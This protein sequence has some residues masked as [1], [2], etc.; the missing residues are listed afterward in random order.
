METASGGAEIVRLG[1]EH[2]ELRPVS[3]FAQRLAAARAE[4][5]DLERMASDDDADMAAM[6]RDELADLDARL[7]GIERELALLRTLR[8]QALM[9]FKQAGK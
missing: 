4:R 6:A 5:E 2:A 3:E 1:K 9:A 7:P 8:N